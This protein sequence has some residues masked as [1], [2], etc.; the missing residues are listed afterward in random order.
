MNQNF[1]PKPVAPSSKMVAPN[2]PASQ[3]P[4]PRSVAPLMDPQQLVR[5]FMILGD[6]LNAGTL[7]V[8]VRRT[9]YEGGTIRGSLNLPAQSFPLNMSTLFRLCA[10]DGLAVIS[11][12][13][14]YCGSS[15]GR[16]PR[17][18]GWFMDYVQERCQMMEMPP[19]PQVFVL[20][21][22]IKGWALRGEPFTHF[23]D[24]Y[25]PSYWQQFSDQ[26]TGV[27]RVGNEEQGASQSK[28]SR[29]EEGAEEG[30]QNSM[31]M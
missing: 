25:V 15:N 8:D 19:T 7:L 14:F 10:G 11:R 1:V 30:D 28:R 31:A 5:Q 18:A 13:V 17:C 22:G 24:V 3:F 4:Q 2:D 29:D 26:R 9:D 20:D 23:M 12:V 6:L 21:G 27:K 16:G